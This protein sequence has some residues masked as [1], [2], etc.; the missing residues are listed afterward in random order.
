MNRFFTRHVVDRPWLVIW[1]MLGLTG[2]FLHG[3]VHIEA[4]TDPLRDLPEHLPAKVLYDRIDELFPAK[5]MVVIGLVGEDLFSVG[6]IARLDRLTRRIEELEGVESVL[7]PTNAR[8]ITA[9]GDL[10]K[11]REAAEPL[12]RTPEEAKEFRRRLTSQRLYSGTIV[13][14]DGKAMLVIVF[15]KAGYPQE[16]VAERLIHLAAD[17]SECEGLELQV[18]GQPAALYWSRVILGRDMSLLTSIALLVVIGLLAFIFRSARGVLLPLGVV[19]CATVWTLGLMSYLGIPISHSTEVLPVLL[20]AIGVADGIHILREYYRHAREWYDRKRVV[21]ET[22]ADLNRP[23]VLTSITTSAG[24][25]ALDTS[26]I[27]SLMMLGLFAAFGVLSAMVFSVSFI[28]AVLSL[29]PLPR[30]KRRSGR[31]PFSRLE[32]ILGRYAAVLAGHKGSVLAGIGLLVLLAVYG[33]TKVRVEMSNLSFFHSDNPFRVATET[34]N[35]HFAVASNLLVVVEGGESDAVKDPAALHKMDSLERYMLEQPQVGAVQSITGFIKQMNQVMHGGDPAQF[36]L[37]REVERETVTETVEE[38][39]T[40][41]ERQV[42]F[43]VPGRDL[44]AQ[45]LALYEMSGKPDDFANLVTYDYSTAKINV[46]LNTDRSSEL[47]GLV[48]NIRGFIAAHFGRLKAELTGMAEL[49]RVLNEMVV[50]GQAWSILTSLLLV[51]LVSS[52]VFRSPAL[53]LFATLPLFFCL[54]LNFGVMGFGGI[55]LNVMTMVTS[56]IAIG[57]GIDYAIHF[58]H[59]YQKERLKGLGYD[60]AAVSTMR[61]SGLAI[62]LNAVTVAAGFSALT[63]SQ[64]TAVQQMGFLIALTMFTS[65]FAA[66]TILPALFVM[67]RPRV[68]RSPGTTGRQ[69]GER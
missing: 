20:I 47:S 53:G 27:K 33:A 61:T 22:M 68:F 51:F 57:V 42:T 26:G 69:G 8:I 48:R 4:D 16:K 17:K 18:I 45:Y 59:R 50:K 63:F 23:V 6:T 21:L 12:P 37:P 44:V 34:I 35:R 39:G 1:L 52:L 60:E 32:N 30:G 31:A 13:S 65:A 14:P 9:E 36:R 10:M 7:S 54:F 29:L 15:V 58:V 41:V 25:I 24:F 46:F 5:E 19:T 38:N 28:P 66:V 64:I 40:E 56:C 55:N 3:L 2:V 49:T 62:L 11:V 43:E 67:T